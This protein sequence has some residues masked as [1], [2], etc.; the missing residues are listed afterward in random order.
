MRSSQIYSIFLSATLCLLLTV[1]AFGQKG[2]L[3]AALDDRQIGHASIDVTGDLRVQVGKSLVV[4]SQESLQR[5]SVTNSDIASALIVSPTQLLIHGMKA[6]TVT[7]ILWDEQER[8][9]SF[10]LTVELDLSGLGRMVKDIFPNEAIQVSQS[11]AAV[12]LTGSVS[13]KAA[14]D[15]ATALAATQGQ[16]G[17]V[18]NLLVQ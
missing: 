15:R 16:G 5:V 2:N 9:R 8:T 10:N 14:L 7:L 1:A 18:V 4:N 17:S 13:S 3:A 6:G 11:G 12:V